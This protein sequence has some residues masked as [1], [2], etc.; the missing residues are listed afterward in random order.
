MVSSSHHKQV[1]KNSIKYLNL[2][3]NDVTSTAED[4]TSQSSG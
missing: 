2:I 4:Q 1:L 3:V